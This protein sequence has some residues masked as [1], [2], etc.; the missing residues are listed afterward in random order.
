MEQKS[1]KAN[2]LSLSWA[3]HLLLPWTWMFLVLWPLD[4]AW[5]LTPLAFIQIRAELH[6]QLSWFSSLQMAI[7]GLW[8]LRNDVNQVLEYLSVSVFVFISKYLY[9][10]LSIT[11]CIYLYISYWFYFSGEPWLVQLGFWSF[12]YLGYMYNMDFG[13]KD[14]Y[15]CLP[16][17]FYYRVPKQISS[18]IWASFSHL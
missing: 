2:F 13:V 4:S 5:D 18:P 7:L 8:G 1:K 12:I 9:L 10:Y 11:I 6:N 3:I 15:L 14:V 16:S 17:T